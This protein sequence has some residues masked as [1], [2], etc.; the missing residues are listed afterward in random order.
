MSLDNDRKAE[1]VRAWIPWPFR[2]AIRPFAGLEGTRNYLGL[3]DGSLRYLR[4][5]LVKPQ[6][7][8]R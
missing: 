7:S 1:L 2:R 6:V 5:H 4:A 8:N 3:G